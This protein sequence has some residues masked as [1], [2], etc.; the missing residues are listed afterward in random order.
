MSAERNYHNSL[1]PGTMLDGYRIE[2]VLGAG[3]FGITYKAI[4]AALDRPV[5]I[6]EYFPASIA[7]RDPA[8]MTVMPSSTTA[9]EDY[10]WGLDRFTGEAKT[11]VSFEHPNIVTVHRFLEANGTAYMVMAWQNGDSLSEIISRDGPMRQDTVA[12]IADGLLDGLEIVHRSGILHRDLKPGNV[13]IRQSDGEPV[14]LDFG[15]AR[16]ALGAHTASLTVLVSAGYAPYEQYDSRGNQG[17]WTDIYSLAATF[18]R[19]VTGEVPADATSRASA[20]MRGE[21]DPMKALAEIA[22]KGYD[23]AFLGAIDAGLNVLEADRPQNIGDWREAFA[24]GLD[25]EPGAETLL[26]SQNTPND[27]TTMQVEKEA[28][29]RLEPKSA[30]PLKQESSPQNSPVKSSDWQA[31]NASPDTNKSSN[32]V[33][34]VIAIGVTLL[35]ATGA[36][37]AID[38]IRKDEAGGLEREAAER[39]K[40]EVRRREVAA[41]RARFPT[42]GQCARY[43]YSYGNDEV[44]VLAEITRVTGTAVYVTLLEVS[45]MSTG[46][47]KYREP[48]GMVLK[49]GVQITEGRDNWLSDKLAECP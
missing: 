24:G 30:A 35:V 28:I 14:L 17:P 27:R 49:A 38:E 36:Y 22:P 45:V 29:Y 8:G 31:R 3:G 26:A 16:A 39:E 41:E 9:E 40:V 19:C 23:P 15:S 34:F 42:P 2:A 13:Y 44:E 32:G 11:L 10:E 37:I 6:K 20:K 33:T 46:A 18:Y 4:E 7:M 21:P 1:P 5:A 43:N 12:R 47:K 48:G 25:V